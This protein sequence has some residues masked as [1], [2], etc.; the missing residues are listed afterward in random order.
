[1]D[2]QQFLQQLLALNPNEALNIRDF[3]V[4]LGGSLLASLAALWLYGI[5]YGRDQLGA[6]V[7]RMFL[8][9]GPAITGVLLA[10]QFSLPL[11]LGLLGALSIVRFR[12]PVKDPAEIGFVLLL[13]AGA[14][15]FATFNPWLVVVLYGLAFL[16]VG[17]QALVERHVPGRGRGQLIVTLS[18]PDSMAKQREVTDFVIDRLKG[19]RLDSVSTLET[20]PSFHY[21][22]NRK[23][24]FDWGKFKADL[25]TLVAPANA[26]IYMS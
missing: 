14:I 12:T 18:E 16:V 17:S 25:D 24:E 7:Q 8:L 23:G 3:A 13:I 4:A 22:F 9:G 19:V 15:G 2:S 5:S 6:G 10:I 1:L 20:R 11:S 26:Q 21:Q